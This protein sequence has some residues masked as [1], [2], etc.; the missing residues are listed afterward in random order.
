MWLLQGRGVHDVWMAVLSYVFAFFVDDW[1][2][3]SEY[4]IKLD[5]SSL[6]LHK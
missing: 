2:I 6:P 4:S 3:I 1:I 5:V